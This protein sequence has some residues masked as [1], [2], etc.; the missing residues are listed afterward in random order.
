[1]SSWMLKDVGR[2][3]LSSAIIVFA[4]IVGLIMVALGQQQIVVNPDFRDGLLGWDI[5]VVNTCTLSSCGPRAPYP[6]I[7]PIASC[8]NYMSS[9]D[10]FC[11]SFDTPEDSN[12][13]IKQSIYIPNG[14]SLLE[15][16]YKNSRY[17]AAIGSAGIKIYVELVELATNKVTDFVLEPAQQ[18]TVWRAPIT[19][20]SGKNIE[21]RFGV[22]GED[23]LST[24]YTYVDYIKIFINSTS[25]TTTTAFTTHTTT[26]TSTETRTVTSFTYV[27]VFTTA[28]VT[29]TIEKRHVVTLT[30][31][32]TIRIDTTMTQV[33][34]IT[35]LK[36]EITYS[37]VLISKL[38]DFENIV[39]I[40]ALLIIFSVSI[41]LILRHTV[42]SKRSHTLVY[43]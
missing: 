21:L 7:E 36:T 2:S 5:V 18:T 19:H 31:P 8:N 32:T 13:Y 41:I 27:T 35:E 29:E 28:S 17:T 25:P 16:K 12:G 4:V 6:R 26:I 14:P 23:C 37:T 1:M 20:L 9:E 22:K 15:I 42:I 11:I 33:R 34:T 24:C 40:I 10:G 30:I 43:K 3:Y 38:V 39:T